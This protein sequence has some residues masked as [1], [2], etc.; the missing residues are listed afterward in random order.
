MTIAQTTGQGVVFQ[1]SGRDW[2]EVTKFSN[3]TTTTKSAG[4]IKK[5]KKG[6]STSPPPKPVN[7]RIVPANKTVTHIKIK[8]GIEGNS[9]CHRSKTIR[10]L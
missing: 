10:A 8:T 7:E 9:W 4:D 3:N 2:T 5:L 1:V 6:A